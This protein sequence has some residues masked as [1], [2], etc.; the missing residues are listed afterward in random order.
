MVIILVSVVLGV[1]SFGMTQPN[2]DSIAVKSPVADNT[3]IS[4]VG[5]I[6]DDAHY[7]NLT[8]DSYTFFNRGEIR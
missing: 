8:N 4:H 6:G 5:F 7:T 2:N 1:I 3:T